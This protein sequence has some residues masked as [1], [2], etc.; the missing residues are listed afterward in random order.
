[1]FLWTECKEAYCLLEK[2][3]IQQFSFYLLHFW[4]HFFG[5][6][7]RLNATIFSLDTTVQN[8]LWLSINTRLRKFQL[9]SSQTSPRMNIHN[10]L[11]KQPP[12]VFCEK[13]VL[14]KSRKIYRKNLCQRLFF[15]NVAGGLRPECYT[16]ECSILF[17]DEKGLL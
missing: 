12:E 11:K 9:V 5:R 6:P 14:E 17:H 3:I 2:F 16:L 7:Q 8:T 10:V 4:G 13:S 15:N 1:M